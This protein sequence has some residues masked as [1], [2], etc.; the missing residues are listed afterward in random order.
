MK[1]YLRGHISAN[2]QETLQKTPSKFRVVVIDPMEDHNDT[3]NECV[4]EDD[5]LPVM[6]IYR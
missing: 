1:R 5:V 4:L 6:N 3:H 2:K